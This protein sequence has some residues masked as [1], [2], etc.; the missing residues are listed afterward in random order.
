MYVFKLVCDNYMIM[1]RFDY[2]MYEFIGIGIV[3]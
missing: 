1:M 3:Y 2:V